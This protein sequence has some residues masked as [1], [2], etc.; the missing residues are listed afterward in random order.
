MLTGEFLSNDE[1]ASIVWRNRFDLNA[2]AQQLVEAATAQWKA[3]EEVIDDITT[4]I[5]QL[6]LPPRS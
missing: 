1:V 6:H 5:L 2:A 4:V 3:Q